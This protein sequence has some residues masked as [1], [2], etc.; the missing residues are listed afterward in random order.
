MKKLFPIVA[1]LF[2]VVA[3]YFLFFNKKQGK[4]EQPK[5]TAIVLKKHSDDFNKNTDS[6]VNAY[7]EMKNAFV[8]SDSLN[9]KNAARKLMVFLDKLP[10]DELKKDT[11][12][13]FETVK[14]NIADIK[15]NTVSLLE[16]KNITEMRKDL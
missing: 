2:A 13:I 16:Q 5:Q 9:A 15:A 7:L 10:I 6:L 12:T 14:S 3:I 8:E 4:V 1:V 11:A